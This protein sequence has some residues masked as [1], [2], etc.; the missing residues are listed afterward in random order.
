MP[1]E[2]NAPYEVWKAEVEKRLSPLG[3]EVILVGHSED[4]GPGVGK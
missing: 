3:D 2:E 1:D 4:L